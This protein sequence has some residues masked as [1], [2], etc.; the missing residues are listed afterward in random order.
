MLQ[1]PNAREP[2]I[3]AVAPLAAAVQDNCDVADAGHARELGM[4]VYLLGMREY[5]RWMSDYPLG[6]APPSERVREWIT[7]QESRWDT[8]F[9]GT[10]AFAGIPF[11]DGDVVDAFDEAEVNRRIGAMGLPERLLY[12]AGLGRFGVP[13]FFLA[14][15]V[16]EEV[17]D[18][19]PITIVDR[20]WARGFSAPPAT[21]RN[22]AIQI[23]RDA[24]RRWLWTRAEQQGGLRLDGATAPPA[25]PGHGGRVGKAAARANLIER[26][27]ERETETLILHE[28]G[29]IR[30]GAVLGPDWERMLVQIDDRRTE[31]ILRAVRD[32]LADCLVTLPELVARGAGESLAFWRSNFDGVRKTLAPE[33]GAAS[34]P[35][36]I[37]L[38]AIRSVADAGADRWGA[39]AQALLACWRDAGRDGVIGTARAL[40]P[41]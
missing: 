7:C 27:V 24:F 30:A 41:N 9:D 26:I 33:L 32:L 18:G 11:P 40:L 39:C 23:R 16:R 28:L 31:V 20:E 34:G 6:M 10:D 25:V 12:G 38:D 1:R 4:C 21:S 2:G 29:E 22:G 5:F 8:V 13:I 37:R 15:T 3:A 14:E 19:I 36:G 17:R 35:D